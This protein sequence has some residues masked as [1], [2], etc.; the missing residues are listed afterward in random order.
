MHCYLGC[1]NLHKRHQKSEIRKAYRVGK[2][3]KQQH[4]AKPWSNTFQHSK[5]LDS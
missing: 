1:L 5:W 3:T 2:Q 4:N